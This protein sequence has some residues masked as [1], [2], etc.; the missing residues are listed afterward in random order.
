MG[1]KVYLK[2]HSKCP[3]CN[4]T[5]MDLITYQI[6]NPPNQKLVGDFVLTE[7]ETEIGLINGFT[8]C[9]E[10]DKRYEKKIG[11]KNSQISGIVI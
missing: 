6:Y 10:C 2:L 5:N 4:H 1:Q 9:D 8:I 7:I 3:H 11:I